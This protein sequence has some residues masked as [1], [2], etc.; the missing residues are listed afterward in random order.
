MSGGADE[1]WCGEPNSSRRCPVHPYGV[2]FVTKDQWTPEMIEEFRA[3]MEKYRDRFGVW[4]AAHPGRL[5]LT[6]PN[7]GTLI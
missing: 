7:C 5:L 4:A 6:C 2:E 1:C 3:E